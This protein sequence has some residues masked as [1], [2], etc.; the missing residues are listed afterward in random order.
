[1]TKQQK[2]AEYITLAVTDV[3]CETWVGE[4]KLSPDMEHTDGLWFQ[5]HGQPDYAEICD[6]HQFA[7]HARLAVEA[8]LLSGEA[9]LAYHDRRW[10]VST[11]WDR[12]SHDTDTEYTDQRPNVVCWRLFLFTADDREPMRARQ[13]NALDL[14]LVATIH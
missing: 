5:D 7:I 11:R 2:R 14:E 10:L 4:Y 6:Y 12:V 9:T 3:D 8:W 13:L 1:M